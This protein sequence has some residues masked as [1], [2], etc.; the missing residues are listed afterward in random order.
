M[1]K[2]PKCLAAL[3]LILLTATI[4][5]M[6]CR[7]VSIKED[8]NQLNTIDTSK[9]VLPYEKQ[10]Q[11]E[12]LAKTYN[13]DEH[14]KL[15]MKQLYFEFQM[16]QGTVYTKDGIQLTPRGKAGIAKKIGKKAIPLVVKGAKKI[17]SKKTVKTISKG[18]STA[19]SYPV[20]KGGIKLANKIMDTTERFEKGLSNEMKKRGVPGWIAD[21][22]SE[23]IG[24][25]LP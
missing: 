4:F 13:L 22:V 3:M 18:I 11:L 5:T 15:E 6:G 19:L 16:A 21:G 24:F 12:E 1:N 14:D 7:P 20:V 9:W 8:Y 23:A 10:L 17:L 2:K 25:Y